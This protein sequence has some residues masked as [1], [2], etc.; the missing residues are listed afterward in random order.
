MKFR[1]S[2]KILRPYVTCLNI[3]FLDCPYTDFKF[4][5]CNSQYKNLLIQCRFGMVLWKFFPFT[6]PKNGRLLAFWANFTGLY[7]SWKETKRLA[8]G[9]K[10]NWMPW[11]LYWYRSYSA[12]MCG[13]FA[14]STLLWQFSCWFRQEKW[15]ILLEKPDF[16]EKIK[17]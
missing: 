12:D 9:T 6:Y 1:V 16:V 5:S 13:F 3:F 17:F 4:H 10:W 15:P 7:L 8:L 2:E 11:I 14:I